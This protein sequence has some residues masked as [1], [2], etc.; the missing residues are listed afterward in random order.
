MRVVRVAVVAFV[1]TAA[2][3]A[4][5]AGAAS[6]SVCGVVGWL[7]GAAGKAC[8]V[9][10]HGDKLLKGGKQLATGHIGGAVSTVFGGGGGGG[11]SKAATLVS[12]AAIGAWTIGGAKAALTGTAKALGDTTS[13]RLGSTWFSSTYWRMA[14]IGAVLTLPFLFAAA[15]Q[16]LI[17]SDLALLAR[18]A[19]G[20][21][22][23]SLLA[24][25]IAAP[26]TMLLLAA[27]DQMSAIVSSAAGHSS[28]H[29]LTKLGLFTAGL[30]AVARSPFLAFLIALLTAAGAIALWLELLMREAA[31]YIVVLMLPL[32]FAA[33]AW[34]ARRVWATRAVEML[35]ALILS[36]FA[37][38]AV[39]ALGG[40]AISQA[41]GLGGMLTGLVLVTLAAFAPWALVRFLPLAELASG[42]AGQMRGGL[43]RANR[44]LPAGDEAAG[45]VENWAGSITSG[46]RRHADALWGSPSGG[47]QHGD[48]GRDGA[49][50]EGRGGARDELEKLDGTPVPEPGL[51]G[52]AT[53]AAAGGT[54]GTADG[55][56]TGAADRRRRPGRRA[57]R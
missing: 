38:V 10:T 3:A 52:A 56:V 27:C 55:A 35:V 44:I 12:L 6:A 31:V 46:M 25:A 42:T 39:L 33:L 28:T 4:C 34:P 24:V 21:L 8:G 57:G 9:V 15:V 5:S 23:L 7:N 50:A 18:A 11:G 32:A 14:A 43:P 51:A 53:G 48:E 22:P 13:P 19:F 30:A 54:T 20:Y 29:F 16:A 47:A 2:V 1:L 40:A 36:K 49:T 41:G 45:R 17:R 26:L 37:I